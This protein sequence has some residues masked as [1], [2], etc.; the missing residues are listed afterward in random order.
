[1]IASP[2][3]RL[4]L[5]RPFGTAQV[6]A[7]RVRALGW[8]GDIVIAPLMQITA[9]ALTK[10]QLAGARTIIATSQHAISTLVNADAARD[11]ALWCVG[12]R[13]LAAAQKAGFTALFGGKGGDGNA[14][15]A[16]MLDAGI[17]GPVL[18][19][20]GDHL[21]LDLAARLRDAG[22]NAQGI[23]VYG[24]DAIA[25]SADGQAC[26]TAPGDVVVPLYSPRSARLFAAAWGALRGPQA[27]IHLIA[28]SENVARAAADVPALSRE[29]LPFPD[30]DAMLDAQLKLQAVLEAPENPR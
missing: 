11:V 29:T 26:L 17:T 13:T 1:M 19:L 12:P 15:L 10:G 9:R 16:Q 22:H 5:T 8:R 18:H 21:A 23:A 4:L 24:Q 28:L 20:H 7:S 14:L 30:G 3:P 6:D 2:A 25:L 27:R